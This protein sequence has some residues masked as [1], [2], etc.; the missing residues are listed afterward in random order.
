MAGIME[1]IR[2]FFASLKSKFKG[3]EKPDEG[4]PSAGQ[5]DT[6]YDQF[7]VDGQTNNKGA[8]YDRMSQIPADGIQGRPPMLQPGTEGPKKEES[9]YYDY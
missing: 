1:S 3:K 4:L 8:N 2:G 5:L 9:L 7:E 6:R